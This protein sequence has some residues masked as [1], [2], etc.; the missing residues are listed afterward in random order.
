LAEGTEGWGKTF[1]R[2][3]LGA[4]LSGVALLGTWGS[5]QQAPSWAD[6]MVEA[7]FNAEKADLIAAGNVEAADALVRPRAKEHT[8]IWL[9]IGAIIGT[10]VAALMGDWFGRRTAY[11][12]LCVSSLAS[13][14]YLFL[15]NDSYGTKFLVTSFLAGTCTAS[16]YGWLPLYLPEL[17]RTKVRATGQGFGFNFG[18][19]IAAIGVLQ[20]G[21]LL[22]AFDKDVMLGSITIP[23]GHPLACSTISLVYLVGM[24]V[25]WFAPETRGKPL[26]D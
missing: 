13:V 7:K 23:H 1:G 20:V 12:L 17:F 26:P 8:L 18:R 25:I 14:W 10:M 24:V 11:F 9:S 3:L 22:T 19:I 16:F 5:T 21:N 2:M 4:V 15:T 6:K